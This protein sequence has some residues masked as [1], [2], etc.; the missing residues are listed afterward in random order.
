[1]RI[2]QSIDS[3]WTGLVALLLRAFGE[4]GPEIVGLVKAMFDD[5][6]AEPALSLVA[7]EN[8]IIVGHILYTKVMTDALEH[9]VSAR[10]LAPLAVSPEAQ[11]KG[12]GGSLIE[13]GFE[14]LQASGVELVFVLG[15]PGYYPR[16][17]F[18]PAGFHGFEAPY[19]IPEQHA[20]AWMVK[21]L[22]ANT[23]HAVSGKIQ[24]CRALS[25]PQYWRE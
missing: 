12:V 17:G 15:H 21:K 7:E 6:T 4:E 8:G 3:D 19:P 13:A 23:M 11:G 2:R 16:Y 5:E 24:C 22:G 1:M 25:H 20:N 10:I 9:P 18:V 14:Q